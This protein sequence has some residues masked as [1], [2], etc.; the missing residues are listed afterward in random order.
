MADLP[1]IQTWANDYPRGG[2]V[3]PHAHATGQVAFARRGVMRVIAQGGVWLVPPARALWIPARVVHEIQCRSDVAMRTVY[4][5]ADAELPYREACAVLEVT[6]LLREVILR[7][8][9]GPHDDGTRPHLLS[10]LGAELRASLVVPLHLP[11]PRDRRLARVAAELVAD[12][13]TRAT[14]DDW[15]DAAGMSRR[16]FARRFT[17]ETGLSFGVWRRRLR[18]LGAIERLAVGEPVTTVALEA[19]YDSVSAFI[20]VFRREFGVTPGRYFAESVD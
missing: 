12:P 14:L 2:G 17:Q 1:E 6:P 8:V 10:L 11:E 15:A 18:L 19:G 13:A 3:A 20:H 4:L 9:E 7:L 5:K 16:S